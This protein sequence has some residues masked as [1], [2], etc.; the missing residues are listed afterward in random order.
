MHADKDGDRF[1]TK[2]H[3]ATATARKWRKNIPKNKQKLINQICA[4]VL[5][6]LGYGI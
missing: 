3:N 4:D 6:E 1:G 5:K 2:V